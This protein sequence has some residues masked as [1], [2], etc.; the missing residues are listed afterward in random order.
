MEHDAYLPRQQ[1]DVLAKCD[2]CRHMNR[3]GNCLMP[4]EAGLSVRFE[5]IRA[6][7]EACQV[8]ELKAPLPATW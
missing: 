6:P 4:Q 1:V 8:F 3:F 2:Q 7:G 5:L